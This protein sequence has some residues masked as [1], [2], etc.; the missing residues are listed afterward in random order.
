MLSL[1]VQRTDSCADAFELSLPSLLVFVFPT[2]VIRF[3][4][5]SILLHSTTTPREKAIEDSARWSVFPITLA[6]LLIKLRSILCHSIV[7]SP[8]G[9]QISNGR[10]SR[11]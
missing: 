1:A 6:S 8:D 9:E 2:I 5:L 3:V 11:C 7:S 10:V 4:V